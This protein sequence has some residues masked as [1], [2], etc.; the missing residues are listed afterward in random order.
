MKTHSTEEQAAMDKSHS[1]RIQALEESFQRREAKW[2]EE[3]ETETAHHRE[4]LEQ[5]D[6]DKTDSM[7]ALRKKMEALGLSKTNE[8]AQLQEI[9]RHYTDN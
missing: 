7:L 9:H 3:L 5:A 6:R 1:A 8:I 4:R 2:R